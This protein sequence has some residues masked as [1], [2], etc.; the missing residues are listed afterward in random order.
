MIGITLESG[1]TMVSALMICY[2]LKISRSWISSWLNFIP[3]GCLRVCVGVGVGEWGMG[4]AGK[5][6]NLSKDCSLSVQMH[7]LSVVETHWLPMRFNF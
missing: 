4:R 5:R 2:N 1:K 3:E 6:E 7:S